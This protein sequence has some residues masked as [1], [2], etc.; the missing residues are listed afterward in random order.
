MKFFRKI[1]V[2]AILM[3]IAA[4]CAVSYMVL[5]TS[6]H[7]DLEE[8]SKS[9]I[10]AFFESDEI[11]RTVPNEFRNDPQGYI[12]SIEDEVKQYLDDD[13]CD[14]YLKHA[15]LSQFETNVF[16]EAD[17][18]VLDRL[19]WYECKY[20]GR[21]IQI[22]AWIEMRSCFGDVNITLREDDSGLKITYLNYPLAQNENNTVFD[23]WY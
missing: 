19:E 3:L 1:N 4:V 17:G 7:N 5:M 20:D 16:I 22:E 11:W 18:H 15:I 6:K 13:A 12:D 23:E 10:E 9:F 14:Y 21:I 8:K 2:G